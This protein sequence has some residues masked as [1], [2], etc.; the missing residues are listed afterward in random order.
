LS[1]SCALR[2]LAFVLDIEDE[3]DDCLIA[4]DDEFD[5]GLI[6]KDDEIDDDDTVEASGMDKW[7]RLGLFK[8]QPNHFPRLHS[9]IFDFCRQ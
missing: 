1:F 3:F 8:D 6:A 7:V 2:L 9:F 5:D 4:K